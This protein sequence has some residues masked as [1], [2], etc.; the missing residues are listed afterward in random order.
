MDYEI[1]KT[2]ENEKEIQKL[3]SEKKG[4][5]K[6]GK[7][8]SSLT[9]YN[10]TRYLILIISILC[11]TTVF[12]NSLSLNFT[13]ICMINE[14]YD[15]NETTF[16][17]STLKEQQN[18]TKYY[19]FSAG[20]KAWLFSAVALG[21]FIGAVPLTF[22]TS[23]V[24]IRIVFTIYGLIS[25]FST[26]FLPIAASISYP[27][28]FSM[29]VFQG[30]ASAVLFA[31]SGSILAEIFL[32]PI[33]GIFCDS[34]FGWQGI[35][36]LQGSLTFAF[37]V[38]FFLFYRNSPKKHR[39]VGE[40]ELLL[41][42]EGKD[43]SEHKN[44]KQ[45][46][47]PYTKMIKD[48][49]VLGVWIGA[50]GSFTGF[51]LFLQYGPTF[52]NKVLKINVAKTG[53]VG[54]IPFLGALIVKGLSGPLSDRLTFI[55]QKR[56]CQI[57]CSISQFSMAFCIATLGWMPIKSEIFAQ[58]CFS[59]AIMFSSLNVV[60]LIKSAQLQSRQYAHIVMNV[61]AF[62]N[63]GIILFLPLFISTFAPNNTYT[64]WAIIFYS[65]AILVT[66]TT[67]IF[68]IT[69]EAEPRP[70]TFENSNESS[71]EDKSIKLRPA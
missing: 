4:K 14:N 58:I 2:D 20:Q 8:K 10:S 56:R 61:I 37:F 55:S 19:S 7:K 57:F 52:L 51:Q 70:W 44:T 53:I 48:K 41:L 46:K 27:F 31:A 64:E 42:N 29:R 66:V 34:N 21:T 1:S 36:Y 26:L 63:S 28:L 25:A 67:T 12:A 11:C 22:I 24:G 23:K 47:I 69:C 60:G 45:S 30:I 40:K 39:N 9:F 5:L 49:S 35:Y 62:I 18:V 59:A 54:A 15:K 50:I 17:N 38:L 68:N 13:I 3:L 43:E 32:M 65:I 6:H 71:K 33:A 16:N